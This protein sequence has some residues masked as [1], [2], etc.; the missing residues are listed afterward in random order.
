[1]KQSF[2]YRLYWGVVLFLFFVQ[3][4]YALNSQS[5]IRYEELAESVRNPYW[6]QNRLVYDGISSNIGW[7]ATLTILYNIFGF[8][9]FIAKFYRLVFH[10][11]SLVCLA[12]VIKKLIPVKKSWLSLLA[13]GLSPTFLYFNT[14][15]TSYGLDLQYLPICL[16][17]IE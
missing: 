2:Y 1:M 13:I 15:Q 14:L 12:L 17:L 9:L 4:L 7:Y 8:S 11:V 3:L 5:Q 10:L 16:Y 6:I